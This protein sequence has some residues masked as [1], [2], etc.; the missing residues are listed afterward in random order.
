[1]LKKIHA[2]TNLQQQL[3]VTIPFPTLPRAN[4]YRVAQN[5][6]NS[7]TVRFGT[8]QPKKIATNSHQIQSL[9]P[10]SMMATVHGLPLKTTNDQVIRKFGKL[11]TTSSTLRCMRVH[12]RSGARTYPSI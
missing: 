10:L 12:K 9:T 5:S 3:V 7:G 11:R 8:F 2:L 4:L 1:V 6:I